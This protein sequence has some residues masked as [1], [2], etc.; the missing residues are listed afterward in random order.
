MAKRMDT[1]DFSRFSSCACLN[2]RMAAR[3]ITRFYDRTL[4]PSGLRAT[5]FNLLCALAADGSATIT[6]LAQQLVMDRTTLTRDL[7]PLKKMDLVE[8]FPGKDRR[9]RVARLTDRGRVT[10]YRAIPLW[11]EAQDRVVKGVGKK[12]WRKLLKRL[13]GA[14][15]LVQEF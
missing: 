7:K 13:S 12:R 11:E 14:A 1:I 15:S 4:Q 10:L 8:I 9:T 5:Q 2:L 3:A 6:H